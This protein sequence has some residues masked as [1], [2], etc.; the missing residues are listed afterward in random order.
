MSSSRTEIKLLACQHNDQTWSAVPGEEIV[1]L[2]ELDQLGEGALLMLNLG[3]NR[4]IQG[5]PELAGPELVRQLQKLS[6]LSEK[7]KDQQE[8]IEQW[9][10]SLTIQSQELSRREM[11]MEARFEQLEDVEKDL[12]QI[13]RR[14]QEANL[15]WDK[16]QQTQQG[17]QAF[18]SRFG[19]MLNLAPEQ[20]QKL[21]QLMNRLADSGQGTDA[22]DQPLK[23]TL[24]AIETQQQILNGF[25]R[26]LE[27][28][29]TQVGQQQQQLAHQGERLN[30]RLEELEGT[31]ISL[32]QSKIQFALEQ[33]ILN[34]KQELLGKITLDL[35][36]NQDLQDTLEQITSGT[37]DVQ[38]DLKVDLVA[39]EN[40]PL[41]ELETI[42][43]S[44]Q[45]ELDKLVQFVNDQ[46]EELTVQCEAVQALKENL[47]KAGA[48]DRITIENELT[49]EQERKE[50]LDETL[51][52][53]RR[54]LKERQGILWEHLRVLRRRQGVIDF[55][56]GSSTVNVEPVLLQL[57]EMQDNTKQERQKLES[58]IQPLKESL[59]QIQRMINQLDD[60]Q[61]RKTQQL[62]TEQENW[63]QAQIKVAQMQMSLG[64]YE[65]A[66]QPLQNQLDDMKHHLGILAQ[67]LN[68]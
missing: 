47:A 20:E 65:E 9:K 66:L 44:L 36:T 68:P 16:I 28:L 1:S 31:R 23:L 59:Q 7:L 27:T 14:R 15:P 39:L 38:V 11:E 53:Q 34:H 22:L 8:E 56:G 61:N 26:Q 63:Q 2:E 57:Q 67:W 40:M 50:F 42:I 35:Q 52:G 49:E 17:V 4:Q 64:L 29:K 12:A 41:R 6:R 21:E 48:Y 25:W 51:V 62:K 24:E 5:R 55:D 3:N 60:E 10:Q 43:N 13:E 32:E 58:E 33:H 18:Q 54:N 46:E 45:A 19:T 30:Q 37:G